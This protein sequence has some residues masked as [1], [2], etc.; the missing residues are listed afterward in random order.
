MEH[1]YVQG[2]GST[3]GLQASAPQAHS[4]EDGGILGCAGMSRLVEHEGFALPDKLGDS[5]REWCFARTTRPLWFRISSFCLIQ[6]VCPQVANGITLNFL[7]LHPRKFDLGQVIEEESCLKVGGCTRCY[8]G[9]VLPANPQQAA[10]HLGH[11]LKVQ[12]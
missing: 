4:Q 8:S 9:C 10:T 1:W 12:I 11:Q 3:P 2:L 5:P 7:A 6:S